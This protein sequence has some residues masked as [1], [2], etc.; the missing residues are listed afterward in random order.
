MAPKGRRPAPGVTANANAAGAIA[1]TAN[2]NAAANANATG[3]VGDTANA[4]AAGTSGSTANANAAVEESL[5]GDAVTTP[6]NLTSA[7][8]NV[9]SPVATV[10]PVQTVPAL[11]FHGTEKYFMTE[12]HVQHGLRSKLTRADIDIF[13][14]QLTQH[15]RTYGIEIPMA[16]YFTTEAQEAIEDFMYTD[17]IAGEFKNKNMAE[18]LAILKKIFPETQKKKETAIKEAECELTD[19]IVG[20]MN[21]SV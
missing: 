15:S 5:R 12:V 18:V 11:T 13:E 8:S 19:F 3:A 21:I 6:A 7:N 10:A 16:G 4:N 20:K 14:Q 9:M 17:A 1:E 2:A